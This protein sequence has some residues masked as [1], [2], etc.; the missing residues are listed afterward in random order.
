VILAL[1]A[2]GAWW[3]GRGKQDISSAPQTADHGTGERS[4]AV[5]PFAD[6]SP[7]KDQEYFTDGM[8]EELLNALGRV[9]GIRVPS[10]T[11]IFALKNKGLDIDEVG[12]RLSVDT[13]LEG[14]V[15][16]SGNRLRISTQLIQV[17]DGFQLW[18]DVFD[19]EFEDV[20][21]V[22]DEIAQSIA[23]ALSVTLADRTAPNSE[24]GG[25]EDSR[26]Y[27]FLLQGNQYA[28][29]G[30]V[31]SFEYA[32]ELYERALELDPGYALAWARL[33]DVQGRLARWNGDP[34]TRRKAGES[35]RKAVEVEPR[36]AEG[37]MALAGHLAD[38]GEREAAI[39]E[40]E[41]AVRLN[42]QVPDLYWLY[43]NL[44]YT[45]GDLETA[46]KLWEKAAEVDPE[47]M[48]VIQLLPQI[49]VGLDR[50]ED[51]QRA[52]RRAL[53]L[54]ERHLE[55]NPDDLNSRLHQASGLLAL[56]NREEGFEVLQMVLESGSQDERL[57]YNTACFY[58][59]ANE[60]ELAIEAL[61][62]SADSGYANPDWTRNDS[63]LDNIR[64]HPRYPGLIEQ[65]EANLRES[66]GGESPTSP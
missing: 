58:S 46:A 64:D 19:R 9:E 65:M 39:R 10:R 15:R 37:H 43:G 62:R 38:M 17:A 32:A 41:E 45:G 50:Q 24:L 66:A 5:L 16:K 6:L 8:T 52:R 33:G 12:E 53:A 59:L 63:D 44:Y 3:L 28:N 21:S 55:L 23:A 11:A 60:V 7:D 61:Q 20:F 57:L 40:Y 22:Q 48:R 36:L 1:V 4:L 18:S 35:S 42:D 31:G 29:R 34:E 27:D 56:G 25:T 51:A 13:V 49:Y 47:N 30:D 14:S 26:A 2:S 54:A